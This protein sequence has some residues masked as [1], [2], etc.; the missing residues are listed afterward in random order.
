MAI[1]LTQSLQSWS[2][3]KHFFILSKLLHIT[4]ILIISVYAYKLIEI[5]VCVYIYIYIYSIYIHIYIY[6]YLFMC[7][8]VCVCVCVC[9]YMS[10]TLPVNI[11]GY[12]PFPINTLDTIL[13]GEWFFADWVITT[14]NGYLQYATSKYCILLML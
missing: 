6:I 1:I 10:Y 11:N 3:S 8:C 4:K 14:S 2:Q 5:S 9:T 13:R 12:V 7:V